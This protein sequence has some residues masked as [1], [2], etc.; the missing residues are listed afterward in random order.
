MADEGTVVAV[1]E[2]IPVEVL[3]LILRRLRL[4]DLGRIACTCRALRVLCGD[5][6][7]WRDVE[8]TWPAALV[9][10]TPRM[11]G[12]RSL[13]IRGGAAIANGNTVLQCLRNLTELRISDVT[14]TTGY[15]CHLATYLPNIGRLEM[16]ALR[17]PS[18]INLA[19]RNG[20]P[21]AWF[22][23]A[24][25]HLVLD[26]TVDMQI[27]LKALTVSNRN[28]VGE[29]FASVDVDIGGASLLCSAAF[30]GMH[31][32]TIPDTEL[33]ALRRVGGKALPRDTLRIS[34]A[35]M[36]QRTAACGDLGVRGTVDLTAH[37]TAPCCDKP[38]CDPCGHLAFLFTLRPLPRFFDTL[39]CERVFGTTTGRPPHPA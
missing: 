16:R 11:L 18:R 29:P 39:L 22:N 13:S 37:A 5:S 35:W 24:L 9:A 3:L 15:V 6:S 21:R 2:I 28:G 23:A 4:A 1:H 32:L 17:R 27:L 26:A 10:C 34:A 33:M 38:M 31:D 30:P 14:I 25:E 7:L 36:L 8:M 20:A 19:S 12:V